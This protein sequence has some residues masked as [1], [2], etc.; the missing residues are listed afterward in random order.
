[1][2]AG[3]KAIALIH[4]FE[5]LRLKSYLCPAKVWTIGWGT[6]RYPEGRPVGP[7][8][9]CTKVQA[10]A[11]FRHDLLRFEREVTRR[12]Q[13]PV[14]PRQFGAL[15]SFTYN[16]GE[17]ALGRSRLLKRVNAHPADPAIRQEFMKWHKAGGQRLKGLW[18]RRHREADFYFGVDTDAPPF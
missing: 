7:G 9:V 14:T 3:P 13:V 6:T 15:V 5:Q 17:G 11:W 18:R 16:L 8:Q 2:R 4:E 12:L 1:M 10:D